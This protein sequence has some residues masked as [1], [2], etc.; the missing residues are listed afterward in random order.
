MQAHR[1]SLPQAALLISAFIWASHN[2]AGA[3]LTVDFHPVTANL[4]R[5][6]L[7][8]VIYVPLL[9]LS[10]RGIRVKRSHAVKLLVASACLG[11]FFQLFYIA[12]SLTTASQVALLLALG[13]AVTTLLAVP[14]LK[15]R[16]SPRSLVGLL[17]ALGSAVTLGLLNWQNEQGHEVWVGAATAFV[18]ML[19]FAHYTLL[20]KP[21]LREYPA[22]LVLGVVTLVATG[23]LWFVLPWLDIELAWEGLDSVTTGQ[24][25]VFAYIA[26]MMNV[27]SYLLFNYALR[28]LPA[29]A[30]H[31][32]IVYSTTL[33]ALIM[34]QVILGEE[35]PL[36]HWACAGVIAV[37]IWLTAVSP[38]GR[39]QRTVSTVTSLS[40]DGGPRMDDEKL[41][42]SPSRKATGGNPSSAGTRSP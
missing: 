25:M 21:L 8:S 39:T 2:I 14:Y 41:T 7:A 6:T 4:I 31:A 11:L 18:A 37:G 22:P 3:W 16:L 35:I 38:A 26:L 13:P 27:V 12:L 20:S 40:T 32:T 9:L 29:G 28:K 15:E 23:L 42:V 24:W 5:S 33:F 19:A 17:L 30:T 34:A 1:R 36:T 10:I